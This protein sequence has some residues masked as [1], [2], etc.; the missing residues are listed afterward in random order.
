MSSSRLT[1]LVVLLVCAVLAGGCAGARPLFDY[2]PTGVPIQV[3]RTPRFPELDR[4]IRH[5]RVAFTVNARKG[6]KANTPEQAKLL[7]ELGQPDYLRRP[8][9]SVRGDR[10]QEWAWVE[11]NRIAQFVFNTLV[12]EGDLSDKDRVMIQYGYPDAV[13]VQDDALGARR[14]TYLYH[15]PIDTDRKYFS[16]A[17]DKMVLGKLTH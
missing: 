16:F 12:Y 11:K 5:G 6:V 13:M 7:E 3:K 10:V 4:F 15:N 17:N 9:E 14:E 1:L 8:Y 2:G